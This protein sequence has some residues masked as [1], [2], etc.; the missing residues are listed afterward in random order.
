MKKILIMELPGA[1]KTT[2][3]KNSDLWALRI[4]EILLKNS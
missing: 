2:I 3:E 4:K 1:G